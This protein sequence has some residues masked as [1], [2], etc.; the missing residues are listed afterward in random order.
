M[1]ISDPLSAREREILDLVY[2]LGQATATQVIAEMKQP[3][4]RSAVRTFL[5]ILEDKGYPL[6]F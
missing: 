4:T 3:P 6:G 2:R 1:T 5:K